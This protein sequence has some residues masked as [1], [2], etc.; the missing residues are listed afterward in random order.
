VG[1]VLVNQ[2]DLFVGPGSTGVNP[3]PVSTTFSIPISVTSDP[4]F[5][6]ANSIE[7]G[8]HNGAR[9]RFGVW[10]DADEDCGLEVSGFRLEKRSTQFANTT[11]NTVN[12]F[13]VGTGLADRTFFVPAGLPPQLLSQGLTVFPAQ[14]TASVFGTLANEMWGLEADLRTSGYCIGSLKFG[15][16]TG[17]RYLH[18]EDTFTLLNTVNVTDA[19]Q[20]TVHAPF[21]PIR[22]ST[23]DRL[24]T[25]N[26]I[27]A[28]QIGGEME[29]RCWGFFM[30]ARGTFAIGPNFESVD[31]QGQ[32][33][34]VGS[35]NPVRNAPGGLL[36]GPSDIGEHNRTRVTVLP[37]LGLKAGYECGSWM[38]V[39]VGYDAMYIDHVARPA[40][41]VAFNSLTTTVTVNGSSNTA[42]VTTPT[43]VQ[44]DTN[45][46]IHGLNFGIEFRY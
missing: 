3:N 43:I 24:K 29:F 27:V 39:Y 46:W 35:S 14:S 44:H 11:G 16:L 7:M 38:R 6:N 10:F 12:Q 22:F 25:H 13:N 26:E 32:T 40:D 21:L 5:A 18:F 8:D 15:A 23:F 45:T 41:Q 20:S 33:T 31:V 36:S 2:N 37:E 28:P 1:L 42:N 34:V 19:P 4:K 17:V 30:D 9:L